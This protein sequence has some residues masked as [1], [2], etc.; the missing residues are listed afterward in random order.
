MRQATRHFAR[1]PLLALVATLSACDYLRL[2]RPS[3]LEQAEPPVVALVNKLPDV[4]RPNEAVIARIYATGGLTHAAVGEDGVMRDEIW[5]RPL[6]LIWTPAIIVMPKGGELELTVHNPG[7][8]RHAAY[9][10]NNGGHMLLELPPGTSGRARIEL[11]EP[12]FYWFGCPVA[13]HFGR[14]MFGFI[15]VEGDVPMEARLD[16]PPQPLPPED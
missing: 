11:D 14:N 12:G 7:K 13:N 6:Q 16:R 5:A 4:D 1:L 8:S 10:P 15:L 3:V 2:L 9:L